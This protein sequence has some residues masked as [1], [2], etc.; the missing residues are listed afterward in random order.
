MLQIGIV[1]ATSGQVSSGGTEPHPTVSASVAIDDF[2]RDYLIFDAELL[3]GNNSATIPLSGTSDATEG[4]TV[5]AEIVDHD[6]N[7]VVRDAVQI[8]TVDTNGDW[9]GDFTGIPWNANWLRPRV[10]IDGSTAPKATTTNRFGSGLTFIVSEQSNGVRLYQ[11]SDLTPPTIGN[12]HGDFQVF[13]P[14]Y[15]EERGTVPRTMTH[16]YVTDATPHNYQMAAM[17]QMVT[18]N[19]PGLKVAVGLD[20]VQG[21]GQANTL[22]DGSTRRYWTDFEAIVDHFGGEPGAL[23]LHH[24]NGVSHISDEYLRAALWGLKAGGTNLVNDIRSG[25]SQTETFA[26]VKFPPDYTAN[27]VFAQALPGLMTGRT[28]AIVLPYMYPH[29]SSSTDPVS[30]RSYVRGGRTVA[31]D[32]PSL[33]QIAPDPGFAHTGDRGTDAN[34]FNS[35]DPLGSGHYFSGMMLSL[36]ISAG[37]VDVPVAKLDNTLFHPE[38][39]YIEVWSSAGPVTTAHRAAGGTTNFPTNPYDDPSSEGNA[40]VLGFQFNGMKLDRTEI[41]AFDGSGTPATSGRIRLY[42]N[43]GEK[44]IH[45]DASITFLNGLGHKITSDAGYRGADG[46]TQAAL[47]WMDADVATH[48]PIIAAPALDGGGDPIYQY[49]WP[50]QPYNDVSET[51]NWI[52]TQNDI[53]DTEANIAMTAISGGE[54]RPTQ[55]VQPQDTTH[56]TFEARV[57]RDTDS[58]MALMGYGT[59]ANQFGTLVIGS[60][61]YV[62]FRLENASGDPL[63]GVDQNTDDG[64]FPENVVR[65][66]RIAGDDTRCN[67]WVEDENGVMQLANGA[68]DGAHFGALAMRGGLQIGTANRLL[69]AISNKSGSSEGDFVYFK[70]WAEYLTPDDTPSSAPAYEVYSDEA[71]RFTPTPPG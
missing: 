65:R 33:I 29:S 16:K 8:A 23:L 56:Y 13:Y 55:T 21:A 58:P 18:R 20:A 7:A 69:Q 43:G 53:P 36:L 35:S 15:N 5:I 26:G 59:T 49:G 67:V 39:D 64:V 22:N 32:F 57:R 9:S 50:I 24:S 44:W 27:H 61:G 2:P 19:V 41:V 46:F 60:T 66:V 25:V 51:M 62:G 70:Y 47:A 63:Y 3:R 30:I 1:L 6:T 40:E 10:W 48:Y 12:Q 34:H 11:P 37:L 42:K 14:D 54:P 28:Q 45:S 4:A 38:G 17:A 52:G 71:G 68:A 31:A